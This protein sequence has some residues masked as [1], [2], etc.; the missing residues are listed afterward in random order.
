MLHSR[1]RI[2]SGGLLIGSGRCTAYAE[3]ARQGVISD[4]EWSG[5]PPGPAAGYWVEFEGYGRYWVVFPSVG[6]VAN[7]KAVAFRIVSGAR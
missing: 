5:P 6:M 1:C 7:P 4:L 3:P 2:Y